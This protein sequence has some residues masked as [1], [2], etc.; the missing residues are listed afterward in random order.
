MSSNDIFPSTQC[1][2][3]VSKSP[4]NV[5]KDFYTTYPPF[6]L[7]LVVIIKWILETSMEKN[8][9]NWYEQSVNPFYDDH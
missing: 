2:L 3:Y 5:V 4:S 1:F 9:Q 7:G 8:I 6:P